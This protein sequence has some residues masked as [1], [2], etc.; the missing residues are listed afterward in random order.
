MPVP[1]CVALF[2]DAKVVGAN[3]LDRGPHE[4]LGVYRD[5][6]PSLLGLGF[7][8]E[9]CGGQE[10]GGQEKSIFLPWYFR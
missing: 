4:A 8:G 5:L 3:G 10:K 1:V 6:A 7:E 9:Y 2:F